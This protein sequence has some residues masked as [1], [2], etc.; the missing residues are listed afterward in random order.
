MARR[1]SI[2]TPIWLLDRR[3]AITPEPGSSGTKWTWFLQ[4][5]PR[6]PPTIRPCLR[7]LSM[8]WSRVPCTQYEGRSASV[9]ARRV[10][11]ASSSMSLSEW[12]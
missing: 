1:R 10:R 6:V 9:R 2:Q 4:A 11:R 3:P 8:C 7:M 5:G 12:P